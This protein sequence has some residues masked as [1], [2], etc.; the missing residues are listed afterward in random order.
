MTDSCEV[1]VVGAGPTG[2]TLAN[3][4]ARRGVQVRVIDQA[5]HHT[6]ETR[7]LGVQARTLESLD[8]MGVADAAI[9]RALPITR[10]NVFSERHRIA[11]FDLGRLETP[12]PFLLMFPQNEIEALLERHLAGLG[13]R[14]GRGTRLLAVAERDDGVAATLRDPDGRRVE[15]LSR[16]L[17][18]CDG[19]H[20]PIR[21]Q[22]GLRFVGDALEESFAVADLRV[23][24]PLPYDELFAFLDRGNFTTFFPMRGGLHRVAVAYTGRQ[25]PTGDVTLA[26]VQ[27]AVDACGPPGVRIVELKEAGRFR[28]NQRA[29]DH[30]SRG[31]VFLAGDAAHVNSLVGAQGMNI[32]MQ[33]SF[34][35]GWKLALVSAGLAPDELLA[36][37]A[38]EREPAV[39][40][41]V[42]G[43]RR[44]TRMTLLRNP[45]SALA[46]RRLAP[47]LL[48]RPK[49]RATIETA[50]AQLDISY[51]AGDRR[52]AA[53]GPPAPVAGDRA[54][55]VVLR[56]PGRD[57]AGH[58]L[59]VLRGDQFSLL[60]FPAAAA[61]LP[62]DLVR[63]LLAAHPGQVRAWYVAADADGNGGGGG[64]EG[65]AAESTLRDPG[66]QVR[67]R[68]G[69]GREGM[70]LV[71]PDGYVAARAESLA[72]AAVA[73]Y[74]DRWLGGAGAA[75]SAGVRGGSRPG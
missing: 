37:Y 22:L 12:F 24:W 16:W 21:E 36:T 72:D 7:A 65:R 59:R 41:T 47:L 55:D 31:R 6:T 42:R 52:P 58:L 13:V 43:T 60:V 4:L 30:Q 10:F 38:V 3:E 14:V 26:E 70:V 64:A 32:G 25:A 34:N 17:V 73:G 29:V 33:D 50:L 27:G 68:Y 23:E 45:V 39:R 69:V 54:P 18:A 5:T 20:S 9:E 51:A 67:R 44:F 28:I 8:R 40:R 66:G 1:L 11:H 15:V 2:L 19:A 46:R 62:H 56:E 49:V 53:D 61:P 74:L 57:A 35:L 71:R 63:P 75:T 48:E